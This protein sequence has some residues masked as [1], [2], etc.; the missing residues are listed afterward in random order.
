LSRLK[1]A[2]ENT[3]SIVGELMVLRM[4]APTAVT[5]V[6]KLILIS[7]RNVGSNSGNG[8]VVTGKC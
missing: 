4:S 6:A 5:G 7:Y 1:A 3:P 2:N 8:G